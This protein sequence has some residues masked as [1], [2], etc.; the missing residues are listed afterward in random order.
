M[1]SRNDALRNG[2][3]T[4]DV[5]GNKQAYEVAGTG[6]VCVVHSGGPGINSDYL[7]M[8]LLEEHLTMVYL[9]PIGT[10]KSSLLP[11]GEYFV[12]TYAHY[13]E[14]VLDHLSQPQPVVLGHSHGGMVT[15]E[16]AIQKS[17]R[18]GAVIAYDTAPEYTKELWDEASRQM[19]LYAARWPDRAEAAAAARAWA[20][21]VSG[22]T[23]TDADSEQKFL[24][25]ILPAYF[26]DSRRTL[27]RDHPVTLNIKWDPTRINGAWS[28]SGRLDA[29]RTPTLIICGDFD[30]VCP[31]RWS[32]EIHRA[33]TESRL[34]ELH[35][36]G[37][38]GHLEQPRSFADAVV[39]FV[40]GQ[41]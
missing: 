36:S 9:D 17:A 41:Q 34:V 16:L 13:L 30:F 15:L 3:H 37:H 22:E 21:G 2:R 14:A 31:P 18:I 10:G 8:P 24:A 1:Q 20:A 7:R 23:R 29:I 33:I 32:K 6:P 5:D 28:A 11:N 4:F 27:D 19:T 26:A 38:F 35:D 39:D 40:R 12:P 25:D